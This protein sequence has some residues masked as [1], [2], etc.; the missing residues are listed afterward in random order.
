MLE[1]LK[2][3]AYKDENFSQKVGEY[4]LQINPESYKHNHQTTWE[5]PKDSDGQ[6]QVKFG[7]LEPETVSFAFYLDATGVLPGSGS[8]QSKYKITSVVDEICKFK[9]AAYTING[10]IHS[11]NFL[12]LYWGDLQFK[13]RLAS[14]N[15]DYSLFKPSGT[16]LR[17]KLDVTFKE[18]LSAEELKK[19]LQK[20]SP[21]LTHARTVL[22]GDTLPLMC[23]RIYGDSKYYL[24]VARANRLKDFRNLKPGTRIVFPPLAN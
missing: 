18:Y 24:D 2:I 13:C 7:R 16:P 8:S 6:P 20:S 9:S 14:L 3:I 4:S 15:I 23:H 5:T 22:A 10:E 1:P 21:D 12:V 11:P 17:A 19:R